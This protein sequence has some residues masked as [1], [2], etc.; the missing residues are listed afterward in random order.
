MSTTNAES[1]TPNAFKWVLEE[2]DCCETMAGQANPTLDIDFS[3]SAD[4][5]SLDLKVDAKHACDIDHLDVDLQI[6]TADAALWKLRASEKG[7]FHWSFGPN[8]PHKL[9]DSIGVNASVIVSA[10]SVCG[11]FTREQRTAYLFQP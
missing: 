8:Q 10:T 5:G 11:T 7:S 4:G 6:I 3:V 1:T 2:D 9:P